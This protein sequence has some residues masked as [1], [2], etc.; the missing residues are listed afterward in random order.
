[1]VII[2]LLDVGSSRHKVLHK[3]SL[4]LSDVQV[5]SLPPQTRS[6]TF[7]AQAIKHAGTRTRLGTVSLYHFLSFLECDW[8]IIS[9]PKVID[10]RTGKQLLDLVATS[11]TAKLQ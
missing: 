4:Q 11:H 7:V 2:T 10:D 1:M 9:M 6:V 8:A 3:E 5:I